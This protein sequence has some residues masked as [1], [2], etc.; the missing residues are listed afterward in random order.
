MFSL[1]VLFTMFVGLVGV[2]VLL[3][4][5]QNKWNS[6]A[7]TV[8][9]MDKCDGWLN[10]HGLHSPTANEIIHLLNQ[11]LLSWIHT[12]E[13]KVRERYFNLKM[14]RCRRNIHARIFI[15]DSVEKL[16]KFYT[17]LL[18]WLHNNNLIY[19]LVA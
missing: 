13:E 4:K 17:S 7:T 6:S 3:Q 18:I 10:S 5:L 14:H 16:S 15:V 11:K 2:L 19:N 12:T 9:L 1:V 8:G